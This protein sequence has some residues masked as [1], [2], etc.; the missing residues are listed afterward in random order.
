MQLK[1]SAKLIRKYYP[2]GIYECDP[3]TYE[4]AFDL[5]ENTPEEK[6]RKK[7][8]IAEAKRERKIYGRAAKPYL[9]ALR[10]ITLAEGYAD[11]DDIL[12]GYGETKTRLDEERRIAA[13]Q[14]A[15][16]AARRREEIA[17][18]LN[19]KKLASKH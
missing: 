8:T 9:F 13:E 12:S 11:I 17:N 19:R 14:N 6:K 5:P 3:A 4:N 15:L 7:K 1:H 16:E 10:M 2:D 18:R